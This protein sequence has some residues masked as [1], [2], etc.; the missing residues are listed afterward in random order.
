MSPGSLAVPR[1]EVFRSEPALHHIL[2]STQAFR[3]FEEAELVGP[4][5][6]HDW[7]D[8]HDQV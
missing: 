1:I 5:M 4:R 7:I 8:K 3:T 6:A 2:T